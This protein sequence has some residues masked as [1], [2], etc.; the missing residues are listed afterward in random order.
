MISLRGWV[1]CTVGLLAIEFAFA[2]LSIAPVECPKPFCLC[3]K[4]SR[5]RAV[6]SGRSLHYIPRLPKYVR[7]VT[8]TNTS[9]SVIHKFGLVNLTFHQLERINFTGNLLLSIDKDAFLNLTFLDT[10]IISFEPRLTT[11]SLKSSFRSL[12]RLKILIFDF[13][14]N[15]WKSLPKD[16]FNNYHLSN[17]KFLFLQGNSFSNVNFTTFGT[18]TR[19]QGISLANNKISHISL[20]KLNALTKLDMSSNLLPKVPTFCE[21]DN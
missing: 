17:V 9:I 7:S 20:T 14:F 19:L 3:Y 11:H 12:P 10:L 5:G 18:M 21:R 2:E 16:M 13:S 15:F 4:K 6:C 8:F 1:I